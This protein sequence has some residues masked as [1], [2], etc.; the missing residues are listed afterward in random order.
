MVS[1]VRRERALPPR[2]RGLPPSRQSPARVPGRERCRSRLGPWLARWR[3]GFPRQR[4]T[5]PVL[6]PLAPSSVLPA[7]TAAD[8]GAARPAR[9]RSFPRA[10]SPAPTD[11]LAA[12]RPRARP[13]VARPRQSAV[14]LR[15]SAVRPR[16][17]PLR[18]RRARSRLRLSARGGRATELMAVVCRRSFG[19][20]RAA[21]DRGPA[22]IKTKAGAPG[23][24][25]GGDRGRGRT[26]AA[27]GTHTE[28]QTERDAKRTEAQ[29]GKPKRAPNANP[30][31]E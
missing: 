4:A 6:G 17:P 16:H 20:A 11:A 13:L 21:P 12:P 22:A 7:G 3:E 10:F 29:R 24:R 19:P 25:R 1:R 30:K 31:P 15:R 8:G 26:D 18:R 28:T 14:R 5:P 27:A 9:A 2:D 23:A